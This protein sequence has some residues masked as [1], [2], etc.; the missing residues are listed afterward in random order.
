MR[1][2]G[3]FLSIIAVMLL[4]IVVVRVQPGAIAQVATP[5]GEEMDFAG[6]TFELVSLASGAEVANPSDLAVVRIGFDPGASLP[7][8]ENDR[9][10]G[11]MLVE[12]GTLTVQ[13]DGP[14]TV[15]RGATL[16]EAMATAEA[17]GDFSSVMEAVAAGE[18][19]TLEAG[20]AAYLPANIPGE[21]RNDGQEHA[22][23]LA[24]LVTP[25]EGM[26]GE[27]TPAP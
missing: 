5:A 10:V 8:E 2:V 26:M 25:P 21:I 15:T 7:G 16:A 23:A 4:G 6:I 11:I 13:A 24:F 1:R 27:A 22:V 3:V 12:S 18:A 20:D 14:L 9:T 19:V 17:T